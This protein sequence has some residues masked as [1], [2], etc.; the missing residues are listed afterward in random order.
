[1]PSVLVWQEHCSTEVSGT[2]STLTCIPGALLQRLLLLLL[3]PCTKQ[4]N[5]NIKRNQQSLRIEQQFAALPPV[6]STLLHSTTAFTAA[7]LTCCTAACGQSL[8]QISS[9]GVARP[10]TIADHSTG[11]LS[12]AVSY[13]TTTLTR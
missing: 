7:F 1:M 6:W 10:Q 11:T 9:N 4:Q 12:V 5:I 13:T 8:A 2:Y 3:I